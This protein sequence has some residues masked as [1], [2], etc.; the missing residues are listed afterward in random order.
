MPLLAKAKDKTKMRVWYYVRVYDD[1]YE[2]DDLA[3]K[4]AFVTDEGKRVPRAVR[5]EIIS[6]WNGPDGDII[7][8][9]A[10]LPSS[11]SHYVVIVP[12]S[13]THLTLPTNREV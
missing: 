2:S 6:R 11:V 13:Y 3:V 4:M 8:L 1:D 10:M 9:P 5:E 7:S 12:V